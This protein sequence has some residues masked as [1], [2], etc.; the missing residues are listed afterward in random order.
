LMVWLQYMNWNKTMMEI[1]Q[2]NSGN[3]N[4]EALYF[5]Y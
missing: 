3:G 2:R 4:K 1:T 5:L